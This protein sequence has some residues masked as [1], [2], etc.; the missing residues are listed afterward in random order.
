MILGIIMILVALVSLYLIH[1]TDLEDDAVQ[2]IVLKGE[3]LQNRI[4]LH[5]GTLLLFIVGVVSI[6]QHFS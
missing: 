2:S 5:I 6:I 4:F 3:E 1:R